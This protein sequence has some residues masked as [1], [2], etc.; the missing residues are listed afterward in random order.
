MYNT[1]IFAREHVYI[2]IFISTY[3]ICIL[4][5]FNRKIYQKAEIK[6]WKIS[7]ISIEFL[8]EIFRVWLWICFPSS[9]SPP[10]YF[11][12]SQKRPFYRARFAF[13]LII[14]WIN[15]MYD[16]LLQIYEAVRG[17]MAL[18]KWNVRSKESFLSKL[19]KNNIIL[20]EDPWIILYFLDTGSQRYKGLKLVKKNG[21]FAKT[22]IVWT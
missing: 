17:S 4:E 10:P 20:S 7:L 11:W 1:Y 6:K 19:V 15:I 21:V 3:N 2:S 18:N 12:T 14:F 8:L 22:L 16:Y 13:V 5:I 9:P